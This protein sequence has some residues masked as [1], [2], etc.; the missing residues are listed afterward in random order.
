MTDVP[1]L[2]ESGGGNW[3]SWGV[4]ACAIV[5][6]MRNTMIM[7]TAANNLFTRAP[8]VGVRGGIV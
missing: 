8:F 3:G 1:Q 5:A 6:G 4:L 2:V 7:A